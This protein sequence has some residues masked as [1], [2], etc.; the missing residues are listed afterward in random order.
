GGIGKTA[1]ACWGVLEAYKAGQFEFIVSVSAKDREL[2][3]T[4]IRPIQATLT[5]YEDLLNE[6]LDVLG[7]SELRCESV[8]TREEA[9][10]SLLEGVKALLFVDNLETVDDGRIV[11]FLETLPKPTKAITTSRTAS[12]RTAAFPISV[13]PLSDDEALKFFDRYAVVMGRPAL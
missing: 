12:V 10:R 6:I 9:V 2:S 8:E 4:G 3:G 5:S 1:L 13:G 11:N 7:F